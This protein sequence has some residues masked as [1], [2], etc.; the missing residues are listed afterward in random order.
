MAYHF[1][2]DK[3]T[4]H[5]AFIVEKASL[6][7]GSKANHLDWHNIKKEQTLEIA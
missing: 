4:T 7:P 5:L 6:H 3:K 2:G 1:G